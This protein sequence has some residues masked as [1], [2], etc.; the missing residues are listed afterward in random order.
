M[1]I[2][3][4]ERMLLR[5]ST[6]LWILPALLV[7][8]AADAETSQRN[9]N[10]DVSRLD[11]ILEPY[12]RPDA[13]GLS[14]MV[15]KDGKA[16][17]K[18]AG[19]MAD[20]EARIPIT[21]Q[22][23]FRLAS[24]SKQFT[25]MAILILIERGKLSLESKLH[26]FFPQFPTY[27]RDITVRQLLNHTAG[28]PDYA[29]HIP[30]GQTAQLTDRDV[31]RI[32]ESQ[33]ECDFPAGSKFAYSN[34]NYV[35]LG[36]IVEQVSDVPLARFSAENIFQPL[37]MS[38]TVAH[39]A[40]TSTVTNRA[41]G[42]TPAEKT[43][44]RTDQSLTSATLGDGGIYSSVEDMYRWDQALYTTKPVGADLITLAF[45]P[46]EHGIGKSSGY[47][48]GWFIED[49]HGVRKVWHGGGTVGFRNQIVRFPN[50]KLTVIVLMNRSDGNPEVIANK[51]A[52]SY[53][54]ALTVSQP[55]IAKVS[56][57][58]LNE[59]TGYYDVRGTFTA[60]TARAGGLVW[61]G[62]GPDPVE[63]LPL[64]S[65]TFFYADPDINPNRDWTITF[66][67]DARGRIKQLVY[68]VGGKIVFTAPFLGP[69]ARTI[70]PQPDPD[71]ALTQIAEQT[72]KAFALGGKSVDQVRN[73]TPG[74]RKVLANRPLHDFAGLQSLTFL[75]A[76]DVAGHGIER[77]GEK[78][79]RILYYKLMSDKISGFVLMYVTADSVI[80][81]EEVVQE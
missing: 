13:P 59:Y 64:S 44:Q 52:R 74:Y 26:D 49:Q 32:L 50:Q 70:T 67:K 11:A 16:V 47:G 43:F 18:R 30:A 37:G 55:A 28:L 15:I 45:S 38:N 58:L 41:Y 21:T 78:V 46:G 1:A 12:I 79:S 5:I 4:Y 42:Y 69:L 27:G 8:A 29:D 35:V 33:T 62:V 10:V 25:A 24:I 40:G 9:G 7:C 34:S 31:L 39:V 80:T 65:D 23:N 14:V 81:G 63:L 71:P 68:K 22:T 19:G 61:S 48:F 51:I 3:S 54:P 2:A 56:S 66:E 6:F 57:S 72:L 76:R 77:N 60:F 36:L 17:Y 20:L 75:A 53:L 73:V